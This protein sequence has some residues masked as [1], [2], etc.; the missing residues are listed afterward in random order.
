MIS[1][2][3]DVQSNLARRNLR[4]R[5]PYG[6]QH[7]KPRAGHPVT[8]ARGL[9]QVAAAFNG[10]L[11]AVDPLP[12]G[13]GVN[14]SP[15]SGVVNAILFRPLRSERTRSTS[16]DIYAPRF[17]PRS[18]QETSSYPILHSRQPRP[19]GDHFSSLVAIL[20]TSARIC[21]SS[22]ARFS[23]SERWLS[24]NYLQHRSAIRPALGSRVHRGGNRPHRRICLSRRHPATGCGKAALP[25]TPA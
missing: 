9:R 25:V 16:S 2:V 15:S 19:Y 6:K 21:R 24:D 5:P 18:A 14:S 8:A 20:R 3:S 7:G 4:T 17:K 23:S 13:I 11:A 1:C 12:S 22:T 10:R